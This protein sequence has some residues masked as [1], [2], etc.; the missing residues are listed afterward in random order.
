MNKKILIV[1]GSGFLGFNLLLR[2]N[3]IKNFKII[4]VSRKIPNYF[5]K[6]KNIKLIKTDFSKKKSLYKNL[7]NKKFDV[8]INFGGNIDHK[9]NFRHKN[10]I[11]IYVKILLIFLERKKFCYFY[12]QEAA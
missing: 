9:I 1:G 8:V 12:K 5:K 7:S 11:S 6:L 3:E 10:L 4:S 2:L